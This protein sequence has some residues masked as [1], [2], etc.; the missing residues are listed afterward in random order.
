MSIAENFQNRL[1]DAVILLKSTRVLE[2]EQRARK[3][4]SALIAH[5]LASARASSYLIIYNA[6]EFAFREAFV[7]IRRDIMANQ[8]KLY[9]LTTY[10]RGDVLRISVLKPLREGTQ[11]DRIMKKIE[12]ASLDD[13]SY[14]I[15]QI[16]FLNFGGSIGSERVWALIK[17]LGLEFKAPSFSNG[18]CDIGNVCTQRN[19]LTHGYE[20]F[21]TV[22]R[23]LE[24][25][26]LLAVVDR[27]SIYMVALIGA[28][29]DYRV[30]ARYRLS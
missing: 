17:A 23:D 29:E 5:A 6:I 12:S 10:W 24:A 20:S 19:S 15:D 22:G 13:C 1:D 14:G 2:E 18:G 4:P 30:N 11:F 27:V 28:L 16:E 9:Q 7:A 21:E 25:E 3:I 26:D 8:L